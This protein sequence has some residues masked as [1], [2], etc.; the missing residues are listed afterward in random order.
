MSDWVTIGQWA[1]KDT[2]SNWYGHTFRQILQASVIPATGSKLRLTFRSSA[3]GDLDIL[4]CFVGL[5]E[6]SN[7]AGAEFKEEPTRVTFA[8]GNTLSLGPNASQVSDE[9]DFAYDP[10]N[11]D[12]LIISFSVTSQRFHANMIGNEAADGVT[13]HY[14]HG[15]HAGDMA[16]ELGGNIFRFDPDFEVL[17]V[18]KVEFFSEAVPDGP[19]T[20]N[21]KSSFGILESETGSNQAEISKLSLYAITGPLSEV[22]ASKLSLYAI[23]GSLDETHLSRFSL[24]AIADVSFTSELTSD[25]GILSHTV[26]SHLTSSYEILPG[27]FRSDADFNYS[28]LGVFQSVSEFDYSI[29]GPF[30]SEATFDYAIRDNSFEVVG[31]FDYRVLG[32]MESSASFD[33][34][35]LESGDIVSIANFDYLVEDQPLPDLPA[36][37]LYP[38]EP[39]KEG[40][41]WKTLVNISHVGKEQRIALRQR[42]RIMI[43]YSSAIP[44]E[45]LRIPA[46]NQLYWSI[47]KTPKIPFFQYATKLTSPLLAG[48][49]ELKFDPDKTYIQANTPICLYWPRTRQYL[50]TQVTSMTATGAILE[51]PLSD[52][53]EADW[54]VMPVY[55]MRLPN[56]SEISMEALTG[57]YPIA[58]EQAYRRRFLRLEANVVVPTFEGRPILAIRPIAVN[59]LQEQ[60]DS[61]AEVLDN[62]TGL[63]KPYSSF[64]N[65]FINGEVQWLV[66]RETDMDFWRALLDSLRGQQGSFFLPTWRED[67]TPLE[68]GLSFI[69]VSETDYADKFDHDTYGYLQFEMASGVQH[70]TV[71]SVSTVTEG[72]RVNL[73]SPLPD[74]EIETVSFLNRVRLNEDVVYLDHYRHHS[75]ISLP[76][77]TINE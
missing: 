60:F 41:A 33:Y 54:E 14:I 59:S 62:E 42:P 67:L 1:A 43:S 46:Y 35:I 70:R 6:G 74:E 73:S 61:N 22:R 27:D 15:D 13:V 63:P 72:L 20:Q 36:I 49:V 71:T 58:G 55:Y 48:E 45:A 77:R 19:V 28:I 18:V 9:I 4:N 75:I 37:E 56:L 2:R 47:G 66:D 31:S 7:P 40:W 65:P 76:I 57:E 11:G 26:S 3:N 51:E 17:S 32:Y 30:R 44:D 38:L 21:L 52:T 16:D 29:I 10:S 24:Y 39:V 68:N 34:S 53:L 64:E 25:Y 12:A 23:L 50:F 8:S 69:V 5:C